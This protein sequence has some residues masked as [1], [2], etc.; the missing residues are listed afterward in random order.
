[1]FHGGTNFGFWAGANFSDKYQPDVTSYD[2]DAPLNEMGQPTPKYFAIRDL[3]ARY[4]PKGTKLPDLPRPL[5]VDRD[6][7]RS[8]STRAPR[9]STTSRRPSAAPSPSRWKPSTRTTASSS[10]G[11]SS[12]ATTAAS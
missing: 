1:M 5:P 7:G 9:F 3:L 8:R 6:P 11:R 4:Q 10:T 2:Y 12:S